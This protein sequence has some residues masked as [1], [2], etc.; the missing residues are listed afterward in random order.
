MDKSN[1]VYAYHSLEKKELARRLRVEMTPQ[2]MLL[3]EALRANL[4]DGLHFRRQQIIDGFVADF[5]CH[6]AGLVIELDGA[7]H[8]ESQEYDAERIEI[9]KRR[10]LR[11]IRF[12]N[13]QVETD[14][15]GVLEQI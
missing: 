1:I 7:V 4:L 12:T 6:A 13:S 11:V 15:R 3:W 10:G 5:Y 9:L 2:E 14:L 8:N